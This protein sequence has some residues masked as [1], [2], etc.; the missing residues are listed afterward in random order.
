MEPSSFFGAALGAFL[1][2]LLTGANLRDE[3]RTLRAWCVELADHLKFKR[4]PRP[5]LHRPPPEP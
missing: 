3:V 1:A 5:A 4:P 2:T